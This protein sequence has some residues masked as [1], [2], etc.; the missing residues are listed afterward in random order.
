MIGSLG[1]GQQV[2]TSHANR[3]I[4][5][6]FGLFAFFDQIS[7]HPKWWRFSPCEDLRRVQR[8]KSHCPKLV[9]NV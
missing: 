9:R 7:D 2:A 5:A 8:R 1:I 6:A 4:E 3:Q